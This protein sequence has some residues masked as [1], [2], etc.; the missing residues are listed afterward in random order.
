MCIRDSASARVLCPGVSAHARMCPR[1]THQYPSTHGAGQPFIQRRPEVA[2][3][4]PMN[5]AC[6][7]SGPRA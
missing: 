4:S 3:C 2:S 7:A 6:A 1:N 5:Q